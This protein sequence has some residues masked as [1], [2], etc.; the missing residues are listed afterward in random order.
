MDPLI[1]AVI[2]FAVIFTGGAV[3]LQLQP[4]TQVLQIPEL[5]EDLAALLR[6]GD[7]VPQQSFRLG[8]GRPR[9]ARAPRRGL[10][11]VLVR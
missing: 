5:K 11:A 4:M 1:L 10:D 9:R 8:H 6:L 7:L 3:G 2:A